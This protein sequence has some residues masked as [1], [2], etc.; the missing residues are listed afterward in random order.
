[1]ALA[2]VVRDASRTWRAWEGAGD[3]LDALARRL[4]E[5]LGAEGFAPEDVVLERAVDVRYAGQSY[6]LTV[7]WGP[8]VEEDFHALHETRFGYRDPGRP[9]EPVTLRVRAIGP[10]PAAG[11]VRRSGEPR[12]ATDAETGARRVG[13]EHEDREA[14]VY[15]RARLEPGMSLPGPA[16]IE[17]YSSTTL[18]P[19]GRRARVDDLGNLLLEPGDGR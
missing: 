5:D 15:D 17:E 14:V 2:D 16:V 19:P 7:P 13:F 12:T 4:V 18:V 1:M 3:A 8:R 10:V 6:E 9:V 11:P